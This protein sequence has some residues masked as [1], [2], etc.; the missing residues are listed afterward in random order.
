MRRVNGQKKSTFGNM[1][2]ATVLPD[3]MED[4]TVNTIEKVLDVRDVEVEMSVEEADKH[5]A[6][7][8]AQWCPNAEEPVVPPIL[9]DSV[10]AVPREEEDPGRV[11]ESGPGDATAAGAME[12]ADADVAGG[13]MDPGRAANLV[14]VFEQERGSIR[15]VN[16][17]D[18]GAADA[19]RL[20]VSSR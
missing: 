10:V 17:I 11:V 20:C 19:A 8:V 16:D 5:D 12:K 1:L 18:P 3:S 14:R 2:I 9:V 13:L 7:I 4:G 15:T 6:E